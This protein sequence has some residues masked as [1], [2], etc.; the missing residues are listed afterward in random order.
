M[1]ETKETATLLSH[2]GTSL[3]SREEL[4][5]IPAPEATR[6]HRPVRHYDFVKTVT[7][8][9]SMRSIGIVRDEYAVS[10]DGMK[11]F[12]VMDLNA[13]F[14]GCRF[15]VGL[16]NANDKSMRLAMTAGLRVLVCDNMAFDGDFRPLSQ[17]HTK[18]LNLDDSVAIAVD[19]IHRGF[20]P[21][22]GKV[23]ELKSA[24]LDDFAAK[25]LIYDAFVA[26][27]IRGLPKYLLNWV[28]RYYFDPEWEDFE[29][30]NLWSL[31]N[32]FTSGFKKLA[33]MKRFELTARLGDFMNQAS[34]DYR[35]VI[36]NRAPAD[37]RGII[38]GINRAAA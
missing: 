5:E 26:K 24:E 37:G 4:R 28:H 22:K 23:C 38:V 6:T 12:G 29:N 30:K 1:N 15:S 8:A 20:E 25:V 9:L 34:E 17:K 7:E 10:T 14:T 19:R 21:L 18:S 27:R 31:S 35:G 33:P 2:S 11:M 32:A 13:E 3:I 16:R 36:V